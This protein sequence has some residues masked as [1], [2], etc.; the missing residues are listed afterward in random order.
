MLC[1]D[2]KFCE[3]IRDLNTLLTCILPDLPHEETIGASYQF[4]GKKMN[5]IKKL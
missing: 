4:L 5:E 2:F 1:F 3:L